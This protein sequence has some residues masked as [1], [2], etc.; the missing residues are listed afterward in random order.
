MEKRFEDD[1]VIDY[2]CEVGPSKGLLHSH[3][4]IRMNFRA[5]RVKLDYKGINQWLVEKLGYSIHFHAI[6]FRDNTKSVLEYLEKTKND[7]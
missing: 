2:V 5:L 4:T 3:G 7:Y 1:T 6:L